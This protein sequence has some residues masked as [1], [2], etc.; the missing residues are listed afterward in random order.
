MGASGVA[1]ELEPYAPALEL[2]AAP[3]SM[4]NLRNVRRTGA[5]PAM[6]IL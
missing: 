6:R 3:L 5:Q 1:L 4:A 2:V